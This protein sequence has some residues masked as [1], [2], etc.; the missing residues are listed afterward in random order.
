MKHMTKLLTLLCMVMLLAGC[1]VGQTVETE[2]PVPEDS[3][4]DP[5]CDLYFPD[6]DPYEFTGKITPDQTLYV[7]MI[8]MTNTTKITVKN[9][10]DFTIV[11]NLYYPENPDY[12]IG[13]HTVEPGKKLEFSNLISVETYCLG[14]Q[15][16][17]TGTVEITISG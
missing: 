12:V 11:A 7:D 6:S 17:E 8:L 9:K 1:T 14:F 4:P 10:G 13:T 15:S 2:R 3:S 16:E 5:Y